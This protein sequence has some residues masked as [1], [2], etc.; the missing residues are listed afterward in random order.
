MSPGPECAVFVP[1][2]DA[3]GGKRDFVETTQ[4]ARAPRS[5]TRVYV[6]AAQ[7]VSGREGRVYVRRGRAAGT[8]VRR[9]LWDG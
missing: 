6:G 7:T 3:S 5:Q 8:P 4:V 2:Q 9:Y 1:R